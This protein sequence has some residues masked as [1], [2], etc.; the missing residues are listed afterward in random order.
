MAALTAFVLAGGKSSRMGTDKAFL[1][2]RGRSLLVNALEL[3]RSVTTEVWIVGSPSRF[4]AF[5]PVVPDIYPDRGPLGGIHAALLSSHTDLN[6]MIGVDIPFLEVRLLHHLISAA[7]LSDALVTVPLVNGNYEPLCAVY[8]KQFA[9]A[10]G[11]ALAANRNKIGALFSGIPI[12]AIAA[13][14]LAHHGFSPAMFRNVNTPEDWKLAQE[15]FSR[16]E[17]V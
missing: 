17:H 11:Q 16:K 1:Q 3:A 7:E 2:L 5:A 6:L 12:R 10:A 9:P 13:E 8:R 15:E 14:E 4:S